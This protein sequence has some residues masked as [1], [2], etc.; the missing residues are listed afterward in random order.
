MNKVL[1]TVLVIAAIGGG[2]FA[3]TNELPKN[4]ELVTSFSIEPSYKFEGWTMYNPGAKAV[5]VAKNIKSAEV[6]YYPTGTGITESVSAGKM[7]KVKESTYDNIWELKLPITILATNLWAEIEYLSGNKTK[8]SDL[9]NVGYEYKRNIQS[10]NELTKEVVMQLLKDK[11]WN[12]ECSSER[13][14]GKY[15]SCK[16]EINKVS[17]DWIVTI[18]YDGLYD[19]SVKASRYKTAITYQ[20]GQWLE[21]NVSRTQQCWP[22]RG[23]QDFSSESCI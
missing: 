18:T 21:G 7:T 6:R 23:H 15:A 12:S 22:D 3:V 11:L 19:D 4:Q 14:V 8:T 2:Y 1:I 13:V 20:D 10:G 17:S 5:L 16:I 9:G